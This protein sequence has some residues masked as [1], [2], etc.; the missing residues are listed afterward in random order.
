MMT[1][2]QERG[3]TS[4]REGDLPDQRLAARPSSFPVPLTSGFIETTEYTRFAQV[5]QVCQRYGSNAVCVGNKG[6]GKTKA[7][8]QYAQWDL[9]EP[10]F[11]TYGRGIE[12]YFSPD[13]PPPH[14]AYYW[15]RAT[16][17]PKGF[18]RELTLLLWSAQML[19]DS[20]RGLNRDE[21]PLSS[22]IRPDGIDLLVVDEVDRLPSGCLEVLRD[23]RARYRFGLMLLVRPGGLPRLWH[24]GP[25]ASQGGMV[26]L[27]QSLSHGATRQILERQV[28]QWGVKV[29]EKGLE[30][31]VDCTRGHF[32]TMS[33]VL[34]QLSYLIDYRGVVTLTGEIV[35]L[36]VSM[37]MSKPTIQK[38]Q[39][40][41]QKI[42]PI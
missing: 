10:F 39:G 14:T 40:Y 25:L 5:C 30:V 29:E 38:V 4:P 16:L 17:T 34:E 9:V 42:E 3:L 19:V 21:R 7:A 1:N 15:P 23:F 24:M 12:P 32:A 35:D 18:E 31:F 8:R 6:V 2:E 36:A 26:H 22:R 20:A 41:F 13:C 27:F 33:N 28:Q 37:I 11:L